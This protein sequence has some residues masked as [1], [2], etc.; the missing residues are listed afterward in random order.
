MGRTT[1]VPKAHTNQASQPTAGNLAITY[2][3]NDMVASLQQTA[4]DPDSGAAQVRKQT[5]TLDGSDRISITKGYTDNVQL[6]E[7][8]DHYDSD[9]DSPAWTQ[10]NSLRG[11]SCRANSFDDDTPVLMADGITK[12]IDGVELGDQ[13]WASDPQTGEAGPRTVTDLIRHS[14]PHA[15]IRITLTDGSSIDATTG[16]PFWAIGW[17]GQGGWTDAGKLRDGDTLLDANGNFVGVTSVLLTSRNLTAYNLSVAGFHTYY[18]GDGSILVHNCVKGPRKN[19]KKSYSDKGKDHTSGQRKSTKETHEKGKSRKTRDQGG[20]KG[21][22]RR[23]YRR[24]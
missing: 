16:H 19:K 1:S 21:D 10:T 23:P 15:M 18:V 4:V 22:K 3:A 9:E 6:T 14:G 7:T 12:P 13:V 2:G 24:K 5:F 17:D 20:E 11:R 8:L